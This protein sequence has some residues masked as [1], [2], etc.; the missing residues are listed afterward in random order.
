MC[1]I[2]LAG[3]RNSVH[4]LSGTHSGPMRGFT[5]IRG[6][7]GDSELLHNISQYRYRPESSSTPLRN[8]TA[9]VTVLLCGLVFFYIRLC[10]HDVAKSIG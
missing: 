4:L 2:S 9:E 8:G 7:G 3:I 1:R 6:T 10:T 5:E